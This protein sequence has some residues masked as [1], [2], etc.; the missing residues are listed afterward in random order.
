MKQILKLIYIALVATGCGTNHNY[1]HG[2]NDND[3]YK[4]NERVS[5]EENDDSPGDNQET[6][7]ETW[8]FALPEVSLE[9]LE[10]QWD[11]PCYGAGLYVSIFGAQHLSGAKRVTRTVVFEKERFQ[12]QVFG[13][14]SENCESESRTVK[15]SLSGQFKLAGPNPW[16]VGGSKIDSIIQTVEATPL[17]DEASKG[18]NDFRWG[19]ANR[20]K[21]FCKFENWSKSL[22]IDISSQD[23]DYL[24]NSNYAPFSI[25]KIQNS[26][27]YFGFTDMEHDGSTE[28]MRPIQWSHYT[29]SKRN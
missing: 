10:G 25:V 22:T 2:R 24:D 4:S 14:S 21:G 13:F 9:D 5:E 11:Q 6:I 8:V 16:Y 15:V 1:H 28:E 23:C 17:S 18:L 7:K 20:Y 29:L 3:G 26:K 12:I 19:T 27:M